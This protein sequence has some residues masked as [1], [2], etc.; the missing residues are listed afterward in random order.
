MKR[1]S[2]SKEKSSFWPGAFLAEGRMW[3][4]IGLNGSVRGVRAGKRNPETS[5][6]HPEGFRGPKLGKSPSVFFLALRF[7]SWWGLA[8]RKKLWIRIAKSDQCGLQFR[9]RSFREI[10]LRPQVMGWPN[11]RSLPDMASR[12]SCLQAGPP[13]SKHGLFLSFL[14]F[15]H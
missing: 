15:H 12:P 2:A 4:E 13:T 11:I 8:T 14:V 5:W 7:S 3:A 9:V 6:G 1:I 10:L